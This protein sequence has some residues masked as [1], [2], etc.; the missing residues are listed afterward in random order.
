MGTLTN[1]DPTP[2]PTA[3]WKLTFFGGFDAAYLDRAAWPLVFWGG[4]A[5]G[6]YSF[7]PLWEWIVAQEPD[8][9]D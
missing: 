2:L 9:L 6:A 4:S 7:Q 8:L 3:G 1:T 5:N